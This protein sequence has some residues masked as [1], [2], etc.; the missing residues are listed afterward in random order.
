MPW[1]PS[2]SYEG[3]PAE[4]ADPALGVKI[5]RQDPETTAYT[6]MTR[7]QPG[8][9]DRRWRLMIPGRSYFYFK[10]IT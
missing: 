2:P 9:I 1:M 4:E 8:W 7:H 3:R 10:V 6:L 5:L